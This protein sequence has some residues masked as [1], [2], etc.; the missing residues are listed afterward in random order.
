MNALHKMADGLKDTSH[1]ALHLLSAYYE[2]LLAVYTFNADH[3]FV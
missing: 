1:A 3:V 2:T